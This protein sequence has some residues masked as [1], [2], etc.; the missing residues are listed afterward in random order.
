MWADWILG[1][2][3][4]DF[5]I[6]RRIRVIVWWVAWLNLLGAV[7]LILITLAPASSPPQP[8]DQPLVNRLVQMSGYLESHDSLRGMG[9]TLAPPLDP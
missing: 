6:V 1:R 3:T 4:E 8:Y 9:S 2:D 7:V 5:L